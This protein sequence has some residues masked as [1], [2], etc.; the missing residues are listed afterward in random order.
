MNDVLELNNK[1][2]R[3]LQ[4]GNAFDAC[5]LLTEASSICLKAT[6]VPDR[7]RRRMKHSDYVIS[8][9][10][11]TNNTVS[12]TSEFCCHPSLYTYAPVI[13]KP[14]CEARFSGKKSCFRCRDDSNVCPCNIAPMIWYNLALSCQILG[15]ECGGNTPD[16]DFY[17]KRSLYLY[18]KV[19]NV[20]SRGKSQSETTAN[21]GLSNMIMAVLNN[22]ACVHHELGSQ[23]DCISTM[24]TLKRSLHSVSKRSP[25]GL[26]RNWR[27]FH[28]NLML[29]SSAPP[30]PA[31]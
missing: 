2:I 12:K 19:L 3:C 17:F 30:A 11:F 6:D 31:A 25:R 8:W 4:K 28:V 10:S 23:E 16:G 29:M 22:L 21:N 18:E 24:Q 14:C 9:M 5:N 1:A 20:C 13:R 7:K 26:L 27:I 15:S